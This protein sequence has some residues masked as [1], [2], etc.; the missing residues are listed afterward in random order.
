MTTDQCSEVRKKIPNRNPADSWFDIYR[1][2][3]PTSPLPQ[4]PYPDVN[5][6]EY[7]QFLGFFKE[8]FPSTFRQQM[9]LRGG[10]VLTD[11]DMQVMRDEVLEDAALAAIE[12]LQMTFNPSLSQQSDLIER[13][14]G[15]GGEDLQVQLISLGVP[16]AAQMGLTDALSPDSETQYVFP[17]PGEFSASR[18]FVNQESRHLRSALSVSPPLD[19][20][21]H[22]HEQEMPRYVKP[23]QV[24]YGRAS[25]MQ[26]P[27]SAH[28]GASWT[29]EAEMESLN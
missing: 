9:E 3:F 2:P 8:N 27:P 24:D 17:I 20:L 19:S 15:Q 5:M 28:S 13:Q 4:S 12:Q 6:Q 25:R 29:W 21:E 7:R 22:A 14:T 11:T 1:I 16:L 26:T 10:M 18:F 23:S